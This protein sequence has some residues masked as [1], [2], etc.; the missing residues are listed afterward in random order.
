VGK[1]DLLRR[2]FELDS[3]DL[4]RFREQGFVKLAQVLDEETV[5]RYEPEITRRV[6]ELNTLTAPMEERTTYQKAFVQVLGLWKKSEIIRELVFSP[7][8][9]RIAAD[10]LEVEGVRL[11]HDQALFKEVGG[12]ITPW[13]ADQ[14]YWPVSSDRICTIWIPLQDTP[15]DMG[16]VAFAAGSHRFEYG[17][18][19]SISDQS[20]QELQ[21]ALSAQAFPVIQEPFRL[22]D[23]NYHLGWVF[24]RASPNL[25]DQVRRAMTI[26]Y[27]DSET[28]LAEPIN[29]KQTLNIEI[30][31]PG[32]VVGELPP[33]ASNPVLY[34]R[35][36]QKAL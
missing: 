13:H 11:Y 20:E 29:E 28:T 7:R 15:L 17:R 8:L 30:C 18:N 4:A 34:T 6:E 23:V 26:I 14:Y 12:G 27:V 1:V 24:H 10:L 33:T 16:P 25:T 21:K 22:G 2:P 19:L 5:G 9:A 31:M 32:G 35:Y 36:M 3:N